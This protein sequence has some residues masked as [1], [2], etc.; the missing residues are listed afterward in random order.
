MNSLQIFPLPSLTILVIGLASCRS[1]TD[2]TMIQKDSTSWGSALGG[3][4]GG[5]L[6]SGA[7]GSA[8]G[9][10]VGGACAHDAALNR[11]WKL[12]TSGGLDSYLIKA[13]EADAEAKHAEQSLTIAL[14]TDADRK[15]LERAN[16]HAKS[17]LRHLNDEIARTDSVMGKGTPA[18]NRALGDALLD[19]R[20]SRS[21]LNSRINEAASTWMDLRREE[22]KQL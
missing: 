14:R 22:M 9:Q 5:V 15:A 7:A 4:A 1:P 10:S 13:R 6:G 11:K 2:P 21:R 3:L 20:V 8:L 16:A 19:M 17:A 18:D 12:G